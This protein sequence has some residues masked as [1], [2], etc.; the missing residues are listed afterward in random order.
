MNRTLEVDMPTHDDDM[1]MSEHP[2]N[3][4]SDLSEDQYKGADPDDLFSRLG[5]VRVMHHEDPDM[6]ADSLSTPGVQ[7]KTMGAFPTTRNCVADPFDLRNK[8]REYPFPD[9]GGVY[10]YCPACKQPQGDRSHAWIHECNP[11]CEAKIVLGKDP[12]QD[13]YWKLCPRK[14]HAIFMCQLDQP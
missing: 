7:G 8:P 2:D 3:P 4:H 14:G 12:S 10:G 5:G 13:D 6:P 1:G 9:L 11:E